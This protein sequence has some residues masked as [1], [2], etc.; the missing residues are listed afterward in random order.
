MD[1]IISGPKKTPY[2]TLDEGVSPH[3]WCPIKNEPKTI[4]VRPKKK[5]FW[6][7]RSPKYLEAKARNQEVAKSQLSPR[8]QLHQ[9]F[10]DAEVLDVLKTLGIC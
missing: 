3:P 9:A 2:E 7:T 8:Q 1:I 6:S 4:E 5:Y 10:K